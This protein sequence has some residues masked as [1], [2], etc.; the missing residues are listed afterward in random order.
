[1]NWSSGYT[2]RYIIKPSGTTVHLRINECGWRRQ[3]GTVCDSNRE[4]QVQASTN[5]KFDYVNGWTQV[6]DVHYD[7]IN[8]YLLKYEKELKLIWYQRSNGNTAG[9]IGIL[10]NKDRKGA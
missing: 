4:A 9:G 8:I 7:G 2:S 6:V 1:M 10:R 3:D 5:S